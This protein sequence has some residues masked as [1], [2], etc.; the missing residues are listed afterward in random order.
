GTLDQRL[1]AAF[2]INVVVERVGPDTFGFAWPLV[3]FVIGAGLAIGA[4]D[5]RIS[6]SLGAFLLPLLMFTNLYLVHNYYATANALFLLTA[7]GLSIA[8]IYAAGWRMVAV[9]L[10]ACLVVGESVF[11]ASV[12]AWYIRLDTTPGAQYSIAR[13]ARE[14]VPAGEGLLIIGD[15][16]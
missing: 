6:I 14:H 1:S 7:T 3:P 11:L 12:Y 2:W 8:A 16:W 13:L 10:V 5:R 9:A 4:I 15:D